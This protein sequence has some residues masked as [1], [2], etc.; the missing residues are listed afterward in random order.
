MKFNINDSNLLYTF[1]HK[2]TYTKYIPNYDQNT[3]TIM[4]SA[5]CHT[6]TL[7][8]DWAVSLERS[9]SSALSANSLLQSSS[10]SSPSSDVNPR[11]ES[12]ALS[13]QK[14]IQ[15]HSH[16]HRHCALTV[17]CFTIETGE[18]NTLMRLLWI[19]FHLQH[20]LKLFYHKTKVVQGPYWLSV[21]RGYF[22]P[23]NT[24][25]PAERQEEQE[26]IDKYSFPERQHCPLLDSFHYCTSEHDLE[27]LTEHWKSL[28]WVLSCKFSG[29]LYFLHVI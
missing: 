5:C 4:L 18:N 19:T 14:Y 23:V 27:K 29:I 20:I 22:R 6:C 15:M 21:T 24:E 3:C 7:T 26:Q 10:S 9:L 2:P 13:V 11:R 17:A 1:R 8:K 28:F 12:V 25:K 16:S